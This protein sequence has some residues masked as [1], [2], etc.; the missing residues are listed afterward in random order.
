MGGLTRIICCILSILVFAY[1]CECTSPY[2]GDF[3]EGVLGTQ[4]CNSV[5]CKNGGRCYVGGD[6]VPQCECPAGTGGRLCETD[7]VNECET[8]HEPCAKGFC[9]DGLKTHHCNCPK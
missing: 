5:N 1:R 8:V 3:C 9:I 6:E 2:V 7:T 4:P